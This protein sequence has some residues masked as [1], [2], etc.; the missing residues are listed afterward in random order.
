MVTTGSFS[1]PSVDFATKINETS[2]LN[3]IMISGSEL[4]LIA[5]D[6]SHLFKLLTRKAAQIMQHKAETVK[7]G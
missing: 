1:K 6:F 3:V 4:R 7:L 2:H 5:G